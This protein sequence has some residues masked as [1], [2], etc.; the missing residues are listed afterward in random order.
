[1]LVL[2]DLPSAGGRFCFVLHEWYGLGSF[3]KGAQSL[4]AIS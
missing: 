3:K 2:W 4:F 1:M